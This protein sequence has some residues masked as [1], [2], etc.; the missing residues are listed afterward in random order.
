MF[1]RRSGSLA[2]VCACRVSVASGVRFET[3][4]IARRGSSLLSRERAFWLRVRAEV[5]GGPPSCAIACV[6]RTL[7]VSAGRLLTRALYRLVQHFTPRWGKL[8]LVWTLHFQAT[9]AAAVLMRLLQP[10]VWSGTL[11]RCSP[12]ST[13][14]RPALGFRWNYN[15]RCDSRL[16]LSR[17][18]QPLF[19]TDSL[20]RFLQPKFVGSRR[21]RRVSSRRLRRPRPTRMTMPISQKATRSTRSWRLWSG[22]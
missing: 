11:Q 12:L 9:V 7:S 4:M 1:G 16:D 18:L 13:R 2:V 10:G 19:S 22:I 21:R 15:L 6:Y 5:L 20:S 3:G 14:I 17:Q 8:C